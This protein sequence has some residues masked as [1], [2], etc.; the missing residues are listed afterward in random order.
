MRY[1]LALVFLLTGHAALAQSAVKPCFIGAN[2]VCDLISDKNPLPVRDAPAPAYPA[3]TVPITV[4]VLADSDAA[5]AMLPAALDKT[6][7]ICGFTI[8][9]VAPTPNA[10]PATLTNV[11]GSKLNFL[12]TIGPIPT[13]AAFSQNFYPCLPATSTKLEIIITSYPTGSGGHTAISAWG[14]QQ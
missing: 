6:T 10:G 3:G 8:T 12:Q 4:S 9:A 2:G 5:V 7:F 11:I 1:L 14:F 13:P